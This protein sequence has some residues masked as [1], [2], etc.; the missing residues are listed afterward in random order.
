MH[1]AAELTGELEENRSQLVRDRKRIRADGRRR[2]RHIVNYVNQ[3]SVVGLVPRVRCL[4]PVVIGEGTLFAF[5][6][7]SLDPSGGRVF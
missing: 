4:R 7:S 1:F 6:L 5:P 2:S 3:Y